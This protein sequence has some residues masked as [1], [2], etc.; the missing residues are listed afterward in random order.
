MKGKNTD[1]LFSMGKYRCHIG[2]IV[3]N[4][5]ACLTRYQ[6]INALLVL[7]LKLNAKIS[8]Q[9][10]SHAKLLS[11]PYCRVSRKHIFCDNRFTNAEIHDSETRKCTL[12]SVLESLLP[13]PISPKIYWGNKSPRSFKGNSSINTTTRR[14]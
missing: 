13:A 3:I 1:K 14:S 9:R 7:L 12:K 11:N 10:V 8:C 2:Y 6:Y 5:R 4:N